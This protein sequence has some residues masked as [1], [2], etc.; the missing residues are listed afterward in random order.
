[1]T[2]R[3]PMNRRPE[4]P[5]DDATGD[6]ILDRTPH[7]PADDSAPI[8]GRQRFNVIQSIWLDGDTGFDW[9]GDSL[10]CATLALNVLDF[11]L[12]RPAKHLCTAWHF[13]LPCSP[14]AYLLAPDFLDLFIRPVPFWG[15]ILRG[16]QVRAWIARQRRTWADHGVNLALV[17]LEERYPM[18]LD[19]RPSPAARRRPSILAGTVQAPRV[20]S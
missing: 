6:V 13:P 17:R 11:L 20:D 7:L 2:E 9:G 1:M 14:L 10:A 12:P 19:G 18:G 16:S 5:W 3:D 15:G 4:I 8:E